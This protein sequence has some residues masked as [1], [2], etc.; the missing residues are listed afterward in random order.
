MTRF[1]QDLAHFYEYLT[2]V[3]LEKGDFMGVLPTVGMNLTDRR[4]VTH[5]SHGGVLSLKTQK[6][7]PPRTA[8]TLQM[9]L[10]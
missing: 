1:C 8:L 3:P 10:A 9:S 7:D 4:G 5:T 6:E 2:C